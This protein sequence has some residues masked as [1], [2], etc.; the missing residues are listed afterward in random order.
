[1]DNLDH[2]CKF[3]ACCRTEKQAS[4]VSI[5][6]VALQ[7]NSANG[8]AK[9]FIPGANLM[10]LSTL[11]REPRQSPDW[12]SFRGDKIPLIDHDTIFIYIHR[13]KIAFIR[14]LSRPSKS[15]PSRKL[16]TRMEDAFPLRRDRLRAAS[17]HLA[18]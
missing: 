11:A 7:Y 13:S 1:M 3:C 14:I 6:V 18:R 5:T 9:I 10:Q 4:T 17:L 2:L 15:H 8:D 12:V 16:K